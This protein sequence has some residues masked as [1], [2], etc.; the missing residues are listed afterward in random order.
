M[1]LLFDEHRVEPLRSQASV[2]AAIDHRSRGA[3]AVAE[4]VDRLEGKLSVG[5]RLVKVHS[6]FVLGM[7]GERVGAER[8]AGLG[9]TQTHYVL[10]RRRP[11]KVV[12][13]RD[14]AVNLGAGNI[15]SLGDERNRPLRHIAQGGLNGVQHFE[16]RARTAFEVRHDAAD[17]IGMGR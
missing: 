11:A 14:Y 6:E 2:K 9:S 8:L 4:A 15:Q 16:E 13:E 17:G 10:A 12:V 1:L 7:R 5:R 3:R